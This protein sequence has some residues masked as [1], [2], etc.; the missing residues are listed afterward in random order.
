MSN[1]QWCMHF[2]MVVNIPRFW[3]RVYVCTNINLVNYGYLQKQKIYNADSNLLRYSRDY[4]LCSLAMSIEVIVAVNNTYPID[5]EQK[6]NN[7]KND[8]F[9]ICSIALKK[10]KWATS[11]LIHSWSI[12][13]WRFFLLHCWAI[14]WLLFLYKRKQ[15]REKEV[16]LYNQTCVLILNIY[17]ISEWLL[18][19]S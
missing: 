5:N 8:A 19:R 12:H 6:Y 10:F 14:S 11:G 18:K 17:I 1:K 2:I 3:I 16:D 7:G 4:V 9:D 15:T 13:R